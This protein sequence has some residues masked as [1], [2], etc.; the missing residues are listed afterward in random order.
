MEG[1]VMNL[2]A[3]TPPYFYDGEAEAISEALE[4]R[5]SRVHI[6]KPQS[7]REDMSILLSSIP[8]KLR[9]RISLHDHHDLAMEFGIRGIHLNK[10]N[11][12]IP[13]GWQATVSASAHSSEEIKKL[14]S[15]FGDKLEYIFLSP[16][17][18]SLSK[19]GYKP[20]K[21][22]DV[23]AKSAGPKIYALGGVTTDKLP[24]L[25]KAG[26]GGTAMLTEAWR[27]P[28]DMNFFRLQFITHPSAD[29]DVVEG[30][31]LALKGGCRWIQLRHKDASPETLLRE[32]KEIGRL[33]R[34]YNA[35]FII[36]DHVELARRLNADGV[37]LGQLDMPIQKAR[38]MLGPGKIIG[39]TA[40]TFEQF[41]KA[42]K[43]GADYAGIGPFRFTTTK[44]NLSP[45]LGRE[46]Y[47]KIVEA[48]HSSGIR[49]PIVAIG[50]IIPGDIP[51]IMATGVD[52]IAASG[53]ILT[54]KDPIA[55]T[56][57]ILDKFP[58][59]NPLNS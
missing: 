13:K 21:P 45:V 26:F 53:T 6:R 16:I 58:D 27:K 48:K 54:D 22:L 18:P 37:H 55:A 15:D 3:I 34:D 17:F 44:K 56:K 24:I 50:G 35:V 51:S 38:K 12:N 2:I 19:P 10:R 52:G 32:G 14:I 41:E 5:F 7:S 33:C 57:N 47:Q 46:G 28:I 39:A 42:A 9:N 11:P 8:E 20:D 36:D 29:R 49:I 25:E 30:T 40:N 59:H 31:R 23:L 43:D 4:T 1:D